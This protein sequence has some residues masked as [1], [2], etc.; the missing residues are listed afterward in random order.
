[1]PV[2][3]S[4]IDI[5]MEERDTPAGRQY[6]LRLFHAELAVLF[7]GLLAIILGGPWPLAIVAAALFLIGALTAIGKLSWAQT[8]FVATGIVGALL[9][10][11][12]YGLRELGF[13]S[14]RSAALL[15]ITETGLTT[16]AATAVIVWH[17]FLAS[18][19]AAGIA[20][21]LTESRG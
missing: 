12:S 8:E 1:M 6:E 21:Q 14:E 5:K 16:T 9:V 17:M 19:A 11:G 20:T 7:L 13:A 4:R 3:K 2:P 18:C 10:G 15:T